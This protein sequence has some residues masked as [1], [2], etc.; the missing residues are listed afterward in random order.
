MAKFYKVPQIMARIR[1]PELADPYSTVPSC[2]F[3]IDRIISPERLTVDHIERLINCPGAREAVDFENGRI[4]LRGVVVN[5]DCPLAGESM[6]RIKQELLPGEYLL[7]AIRRGNR[8]II[9]R[10]DTPLRIGDTAYLIASAKTMAKVIEGFV[11]GVRPA[12]R[13]IIAGSGVTGL[14]LARRLGPKLDRVILIEPDEVQAERAAIALD[15]KGVEVLLGSALDEDL[16]VR[17]GPENFDHF[18]GIGT[19]DEK[20]VMG[21]LLFRKNGGGGEPIVMTGQPHY[22]DVL[23]TLDLELAINPRAL[24]VSEILGHIRGGSILNVAKLQIED[25]EVLEIKID[26]DSDFCGKQVKNLRPALGHLVAAV[27]RD[28]DVHIPD[29]EFEILSGDKVLIFVGAKAHTSLMKLLR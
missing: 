29:G 9:P 16:L 10:G 8:V 15:H 7:A 14:A 26:D 27:L 23:E 1:D 22:L 2:T 6:Q 11:P 12:R 20:N 5:E 25:A 19:D 3:G 24:A 28:R 21:A 18:I 13:V 4:A 17:L